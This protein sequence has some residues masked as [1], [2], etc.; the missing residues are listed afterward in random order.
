[1]SRRRKWDFPNSSIASSQSLRNL[2]KVSAKHERVF[3]LG[4]KGM[5][6]IL[7]PII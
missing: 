3:P 7:Y 5:C 4:V 6:P 2:F 1:M